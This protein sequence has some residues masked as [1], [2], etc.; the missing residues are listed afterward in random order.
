MRASCVESIFEFED[1]FT[2]KKLCQNLICCGHGDSGRGNYYLI[3][4]KTL[5]G[6]KLFQKL[7]F[8]VHTYKRTIYMTNCIVTR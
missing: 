2:I 6:S 7:Y 8:T 4:P 5:K 3:C 1:L